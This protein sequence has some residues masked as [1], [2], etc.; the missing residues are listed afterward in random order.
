[1]FSRTTNEATTTTTNTTDE[2]HAVYISHK[3]SQFKIAVDISIFLLSFLLTFL[4]I[5]MHW[6]AE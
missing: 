4:S 6:V 5:S 2:M 3:N 1:M